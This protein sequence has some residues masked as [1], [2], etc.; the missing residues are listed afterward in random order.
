MVFASVE[1]L[2]LLFPITL[3]IYY[4]VGYATKA[5][6]P[7]NLVMLTASLLFYYWGG[8]SYT[9]VLLLVITANYILG[10]VIH[11]FDG[12]SEGLRKA[13]V[14]A[15]VVINL[16]VLGYYKYIGFVVSQ[17]ALLPDWAPKLD[18]AAYKIILPIGISFYIFQA[19]SYLIDVYRREAV[20]QR[21]FLNFALYISMFPQL[22]AGPIVRYALIA[23]QI[24]HRDTTPSV[25]QFAD[26]VTRFCIGFA[27]K[28]IIADTMAVVADAVYAIPGGDMSAPTAWLGL[29]C[30]TFQI[31]FDFS[32]YSDMAIGLGLMFGFKFPENFNRPYAAVSITD[33]WRRWHMTLSSWFRDYV[34]IPLG[35]SR[36]ST[37]RTYANL[38]LVFM[39]TGFWH[40]A[41]WTFIFWGAYHGAWL[42]IERIFGLRT[43]ENGRSEVLHRLVTFTIVCLGWNLFRADSLTH[44][45]QI[46]QSLFAGGFA[47][48][49]ASVAQFVTNYFIAIFTLAVAILLFSQFRSLRDMA[50][51]AGSRFGRAARIALVGAAFPYAIMLLVS[52][53]FSAFI[54][55][56]F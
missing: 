16:A 43:V 12:R 37:A 30:Y 40:G 24:N 7:L 55:Y 36:G 19:M 11:H 31:Y 10:L 35:G 38:W 41:N 23:E 32:A 8:G 22:I 56:Q 15:G 21:N 6:N 50:M 18:P 48:P 33:F 1:F 27:K 53:T 42:I 25:N 9:I 28:V 34:Y 46:Y 51:D 14:A 39:A 17:L 4:L 49:P 45:G 26:G 2:F 47:M 54:Y 29:I 5:V 13:A 20:Y 3:L 52:G 44:A